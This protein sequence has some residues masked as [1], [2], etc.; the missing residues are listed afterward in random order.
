M[1]G[2]TNSHQIDLL[3][4]IESSKWS[5]LPIEEQLEQR[6]KEALYYREQVN[7]QKIALKCYRKK[8]QRIREFWKNKIYNES[9]RSGKVLKKAMQRS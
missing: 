1:D 5:G 7:K 3:S 4:L 8:V 6:T 2:R 9:T